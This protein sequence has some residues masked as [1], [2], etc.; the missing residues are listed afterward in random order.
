MVVICIQDVSEMLEQTSGTS[1]LH[2]NKEGNYVCPQTV[3][4]VMPQHY[5]DLKIFY[6]CGKLKTLVC[7]ATIENGQTFRQHICD[8]RQTIRIRPGTFHRARQSMI[9]RVHV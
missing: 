5:P 8:A 9:R 7:S 2:R 4:E 3:F 1:S 6:V